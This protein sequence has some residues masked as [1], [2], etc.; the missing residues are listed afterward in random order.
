[1]EQAVSALTHVVFLPTRPQLVIQQV[2]GGNSRNCYRE[3]RYEVVSRVPLDDVAFKRLDEC[4]LLGLGQA[5]YVSAP[6]TFEEP[7]PP[8][9]VDRRTGAP[10]GEP[11]VTYKGE[12]IT[13]TVNYTYH[14][15]FVTRVCDSGD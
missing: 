5:Y 8:V 15:Y 9:T 6:Q 2:P 10:T 11:P 7:A 4:G 1:M 12:P 3:T 14:R 13:N